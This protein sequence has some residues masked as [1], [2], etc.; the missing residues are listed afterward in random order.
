MCVCVYMSYVY[1]VGAHEA[2]RR[3]WAPAHTS[4]SLQLYTEAKSKS[5]TRAVQTPET[6]ISL[7]PH[8]IILNDFCTHFAPRTGRYIVIYFE[9]E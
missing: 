9:K 4:G 6:E 2:R 5:S 7:Q 8:K 1:H 3:H